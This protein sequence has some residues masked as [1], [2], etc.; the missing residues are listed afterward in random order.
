[1]PRERLSKPTVAAGVEQYG[2]GSAALDLANVKFRGVRKRP[3]GRF[4]AE[5]RDPLKKTRVWLG[6]FESAEDAARAYDA[7]AWSL[8]GP[9]A[10]TNFP[11]SFIS[12]PNQTLYPFRLQTNGAVTGAAMD[13]LRGRYNGNAVEIDDA[14]EDDGGLNFQ[15][16]A[17]SSMSSTVES[18]SGPRPIL[19]VKISI[20]TMKTE[21]KHQRSPPISP[22]DYQSDCDSSSSVIDGDAAR[23]FASSSSS[24]RKLLPFDLNFPPLGDA[25]LGSDGDDLHVTDLRL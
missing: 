17:S 15:R 12:P 23:D 13:Q 22:E 16:P 4:A 6:T 25:D 21:R 24:F 14:E 3:W 2:N 10:K 20:A 7:A 19:A 8:R 11:I 18:Y 9:K 5:I 1:M